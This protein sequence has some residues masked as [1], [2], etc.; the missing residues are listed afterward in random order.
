[1]LGRLARATVGGAALAGGAL[2]ASGDEGRRSLLLSL[3][4]LD[5]KLRPTLAAA[6]PPDAF[7]VDVGC[8]TGLVSMCGSRS[9]MMEAG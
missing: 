5:D 6:L 4:R 2:V 7:V 3:A 8:S 9:R 1:M